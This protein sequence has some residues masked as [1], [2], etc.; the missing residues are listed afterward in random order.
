MA[1]HPSASLPAV[2]SHLQVMYPEVHRLVPEHG[3]VLDA[4]KQYTQE[5]EEEVTL[6]ED[7]G[8]CCHYVAHAVFLFLSDFL[9]AL[10]THILTCYPYCPST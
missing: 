5:H 2:Y 10:L 1:H 4:T 9:C 6:L 3:S 8:R 7:L